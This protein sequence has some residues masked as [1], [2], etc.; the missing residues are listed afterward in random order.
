MTGLGVL[1]SG[2]RSQAVGVSADG[3]VV[4]RYSGPYGDPALLGNLPGEEEKC[5]PTLNEASR[6]RSSR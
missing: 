3:S 6:P 2:N 4:L 5:T 1:P